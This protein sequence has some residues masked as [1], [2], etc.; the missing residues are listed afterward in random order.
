MSDK[1][2]PDGT[3]NV[4]FLEDVISEKWGSGTARVMC[5][6]TDP[7]VRHHGALGSFVRVHLLKNEDRVAD[8][9]EYC[10]TFPQVA[11]VLEDNEACEKFDLP[12]DRE[13]E[14]VAVS[15]KNAVIGSRKDEHDLSNLGGYRLRSHGGISEQGIPLLMSR[16]AKYGAETPSRQWRNFDAFDL[17]LNF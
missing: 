6:I 13:G 5:P 1:C 10:K 11:L 16:P 7:F 9:V 12:L 4:L 15:I 14:F 3:P 17:V 8:I 2:N